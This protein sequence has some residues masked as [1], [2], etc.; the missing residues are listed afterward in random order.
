MHGEPRVEVQHQHD[1]NDGSSTTIHHSFW[2]E[3]ASE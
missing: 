3:L 2:L 1:V